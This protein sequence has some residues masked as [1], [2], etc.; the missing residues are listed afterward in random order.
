MA[1]N[2][3]IDKHLEINYCKKV[4]SVKCVKIFAKLFKCKEYEFS[5][6]RV[7]VF[8]YRHVGTYEKLSAKF[9]LLLA[10]KIG[11]GNGGIS[12]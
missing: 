4:F 12:G 1:I 9:T 3:F 2:F 10:C 11:M 8:I 7:N 5:I 6:G